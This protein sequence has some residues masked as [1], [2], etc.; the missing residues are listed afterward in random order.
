MLGY[1]NAFECKLKTKIIVNEYKK[2]PE[3]DHIT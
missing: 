2:S 3:I 1:E